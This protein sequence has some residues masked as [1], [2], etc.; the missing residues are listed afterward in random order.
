M[1]GPLKKII[2]PQKEQRGNIFETA[3]DIAKKHGICMRSGTTNRA[4]G[5]CL[6]EAVQDNVNQRD[7]F[8][9]NLDSRQI[10]LLE[11]HPLYF[12]L[13]CNFP[14]ITPWP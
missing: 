2:H 3:I 5:H 14:S 10:V 1:T 13:T 8:S 4:N 9:E 7:C 12:R 6:Y 11:P